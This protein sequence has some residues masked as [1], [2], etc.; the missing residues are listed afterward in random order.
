MG[1][2]VEMIAAFLFE[3]TAN[4]CD[5][6]NKMKKSSMSGGL[7]LVFEDKTLDIEAH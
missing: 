2:D 5:S 7:E 1:D 3:T 4:P 6:A